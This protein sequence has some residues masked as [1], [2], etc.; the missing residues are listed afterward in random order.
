MAH[1]QSELGDQRT[2]NPIQVDP[3]ASTQPR[4]DSTTDA[5]SPASQIDLQLARRA[6]RSDCTILIT[7]ETGSGKG[8]FARWLHQHSRRHDRAFIPVN[9]GAVPESLIDSQLFGHVKGSFSGATANHIGLVRAAEKGTLLLDEVSELP[10]TAQLRLLRLLQ[11]REVQPVGHPQPILVDVRVMAATNIDLDEAV[12]DKNFREDLF[13]RLNVIQI[14]VP[15]LRERTHQIPQLLLAFNREF[16]DL[17]QQPEL[18]FN[19]DARQLLMAYHWPGNIREL[20]TVVE[21][22]HVLCTDGNVDADILRGFGKLQMPGISDDL[23]REIDHAK[24]QQVER[25]MAETGGSVARAA[26]IFGVHRSTIYRWLQRSD[27]QCDTN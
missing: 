9:C 13:F 26:A 1:R 18:S 21:R 6:A 19:D 12:A 10:H 16:S 15:P 8:H 4:Q 14:E 2:N 20:R 22:L 23:Q 27:S 3:L 5:D 7:G 17:Y 11:D 25:V 24:R